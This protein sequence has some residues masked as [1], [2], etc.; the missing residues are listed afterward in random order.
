MSNPNQSNQS[1]S[2]V[3]RSPRG[4]DTFHFAKTT[5]VS[6]VIEEARQRFG[7]EPGA[8]V[9]KRERD[10]SALAPERPLVSYHLDDGE[11]LLLVPEMGSGV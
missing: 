1:I 9:L 6:D 5:K 7:F 11:V 4:S 3:I 8:F 2:V 10:G